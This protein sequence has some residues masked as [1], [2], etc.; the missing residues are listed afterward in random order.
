MFSFI[1]K[2]PTIVFGLGFPL[3][4]LVII[5]LTSGLSVYF[6]EPPKY[7]LIYATE[8]ENYSDKF[9]IQVVNN[10]VQ[11][12]YNKKNNE[13]VRVPKLWYYN[14][15]SGAQHEI[16]IIIPNDFTATNIIAIP[17]LDKLE[18][19]SASISPDGYE[20]RVSNRRTNTI[21][22]PLESY[23]DKPVL[24]KSNRS[25]QIPISV[26]NYYAYGT[27]FIGWVMNE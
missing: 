14:A 11:V 9:N 23:R 15:K 10:K 27:K 7:D 17:E 3:L 8:Y 2:N 18:V 22:F 6:I 4:I 1:R 21:F 24:V 25:I 5:L 20:F 26:N 16:P 19:S 13:Y 12:Y